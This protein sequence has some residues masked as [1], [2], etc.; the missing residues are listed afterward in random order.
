MDNTNLKNLTT[1]QLEEIDGGFAPAVIAAGKI[2]LGGIG[3]GIGY[4]GLKEI[5]E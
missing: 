4:F 2:I 5:F 3:Y 1:E